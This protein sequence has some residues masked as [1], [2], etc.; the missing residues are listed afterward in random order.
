MSYQ[1]LESSLGYV[2]KNKLL[3][4]EALTH[5]SYRNENR[6]HHTPNNERLEFLG[7]AVLELV[8]S[9]DIFLRFP[10]KKE[11]ELTSLRSCLVNGDVAASIA[12]N[13]G[14]Y[15]SV[16]L[17]KGERKNTASRGVILADTFEAIIGAMY[18]DGGMDSAKQ[19]ITK[20]VL[21]EANLAITDTLDPKSK[22]QELAQ[23]QVGLTP[24]YRLIREYGPD[25]DK[26]FLIGV[27]IG[28]TLFAEGTGRSKLKAETEAARVAL[29]KMQ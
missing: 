16:M 8:V 4:V 11:G 24:T 21:T 25:H 14:L 17:S 20:L 15:E 6:N 9:E 28:D 2:F 29:G 22:L 12:E 13:L 10:E 27:Y 23:Q 26:A 5:R 3:L 1:K 7:D 18:L 19:F